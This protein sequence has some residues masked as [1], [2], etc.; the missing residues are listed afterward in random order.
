[1][2]NIIINNKIS[3]MIKTLKLK[4]KFENSSLPRGL[5]EERKK[6]QYNNRVTRGLSDDIAHDN[7]KKNF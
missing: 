5:N 6:R 1:M 7:N 2:R 3:K 4:K